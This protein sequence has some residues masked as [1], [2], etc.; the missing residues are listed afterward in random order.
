[1]EQVLLDS[2]II[3]YLAQPQYS[4]LS[5]FIQSFHISYSAISKIEV[6]GYHR[7][8][9]A[10]RSSFEVFFSHIRGYD[11]SEEIVQKAIDLKQV[12]KMSLGDSLVAATALVYGLPLLTRNLRDFSHITGPDVRNPFDALSI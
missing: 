2:N 5:T 7:L 12:Q 1:M 3:I 8:S 9:S 10:D 4:E 11:I 6:L